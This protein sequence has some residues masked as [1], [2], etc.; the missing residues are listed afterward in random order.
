MTFGVRITTGCKEGRAH[1][2]LVCMFLFLKRRPVFLRKAGT[3]RLL[4]VG[5]DYSKV[6]TTNAK[7]DIRTYLLLFLPKPFI[8]TKGSAT[9]G[10]IDS[11][12]KGNKQGSHAV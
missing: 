4:R 7:A 6:N 8:M 9:N 12:R 3:D 2:L 1:F 5:R 10:G 11:L